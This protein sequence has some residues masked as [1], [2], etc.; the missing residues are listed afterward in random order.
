MRTTLHNWKGSSKRTSFQGYVGLNL[1]MSKTFG[2]SS[3][4]FYSRDVKTNKGKHI[5]FVLMFFSFSKYS[6]ES[7]SHKDS[8]NYEEKK[9]LI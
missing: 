6:G 2:M 1:A 4:Q 7:C 5:Y 3:N 9:T 8:P